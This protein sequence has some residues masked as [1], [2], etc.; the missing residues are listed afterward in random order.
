MG[1]I[2]LAVAIVTEV[3]ATTFL[4]YTS[5]PSPKWWAYAIVVAGYFASFSALSQSLS[6]GVPL[7]IA[8]AIWSAVGVTIIALISW[9]F[10]SEALTW[11][12]IVG[13][14]LVIGGGGLLEI[15]RKH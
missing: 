3:I 2:F 8:Y 4:K 10:F 1:Y 9:L 13:L 15:G 5:G 7:G 11:V 12:Q 6:R 14:V